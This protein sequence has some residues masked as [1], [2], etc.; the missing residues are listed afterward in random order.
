RATTFHAFCQEILQR[1]PVEAAV[2]PGF[3]LLDGEAELIDEAWDALY[4]EATRTP[5]GPLAQTLETLFDAGGGLSGTRQALNGFLAQRIDWWAFTQDQRDALA[6]AEAR[7]RELYGIAPDHDPAAGFFTPAQCA[8]LGEFAALLGRHMIKSNLEHQQCLDAALALHASD[9]LAALELT[10][11]ALLTQSGE[12]RKR[13]PSK[14]QENSLGTEGSARLL[15][16]HEQLCAAL[17]ETRDQLARQTSLALTCAWYRAGQRLLEHYQRIKREQRVLDFADLEWHAYRLLNGSE[18]AHWVQYKLDARIDHFL[19]DEFQDTNPTQWRLLLPLLDELAAGGSERARSVFLVG[20]AKQS[21][22]R[23]RRADARLLETASRWL[24]ERLDAQRFSLESSRRSAPA[25]ID[26]VNRAFADGPLAEALPDFPPHSTHRDDLWGHVE[27]LP[28]FAPEASPALPARPGLRNP[29]EEPRPTPADDPHEREGRA[30]AARIRALI[31]APTLIGPADDAR[32]LR[33][34][35]VLI[36][37]RNRTH[38]TSYEKALRDAGI[39]YLGAARGTLL[40]SLEIRDLEALLNTLIAP[41]DNLALAQVLRSPLFAADDADLVTLAQA[42]GDTWMQRLLDS[43]PRQPDGAPL[44]RAARLLPVWSDRVGR[45]PV[46]D[47]L[48]RIYHEGDVLARFDAA[49]TPALKPRVRANLIRF[50]ELALEVDS[51][52]YPSLPHFVARLGELRQRAADAPDDAP[53][54]SGGGERVQFLTVHGAKGLEAPVVF[55]ADSGG[56]TSRDR[57]A[58]QALVDW[59]AD[60]DRPRH[61]LLVGRKADR[62]SVTRQLLERQQRAEQREDANLLYVAL[63]RARQML[64]VS[65]AVTD[66][67]ADSGWYGLLR[68]QWDRDGCLTRG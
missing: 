15:E 21:I 40:D 44:A 42:D 48:D 34:G 1:F 16:L 8:L 13:K 30:I 53:P 33:Y 19:I 58:W 51:G 4:A 49:A 11:R 14:A 6:H 18:Q 7:A 68:A 59:P 54:E 25:I 28:P 9:A 37:L 56:N 55:L 52:R 32:P 22:Y 50:I 10:A 12:P 23:F 27:L 39:P 62:D 36:L 66:D 57:N 64:C 65:A 45:L 43:G 24:E 17:L 38:A 60:A 26:G 20:D 46:H 41:Q 31:D 35:D 67:T 47:L 61:L 3:E 63:T 29:L 2:P 5:D